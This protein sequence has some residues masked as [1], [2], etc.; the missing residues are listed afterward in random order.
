MPCHSD[1]MERLDAGR[2]LAHQSNVEY[3]RELT[4][5]S[6]GRVLDADGLTCVASPHPDP[7]LLN[8][9]FATDRD[10]PAHDF[11]DRARDFFARAERRYSFHALVGRDEDLV[12]RALKLGFTG[13]EEPDPLQVREAAPIKVAVPPGLELRPGP[14]RTRRR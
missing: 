2:E 9:A 13:G 8:A 6:G 5:R 7:H 10:F 1:R 3:F 11:F 12:A 14:R 4:R